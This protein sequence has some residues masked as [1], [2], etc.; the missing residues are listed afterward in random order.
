VDITRAAIEKNRIT[1]AILVIVLVGGWN[2]FNTLPRAEDPGFTIR[3]AQVITSFPGASP[4]RVEDLITDRLEKAIRELPEL[5]SIE[6]VSKTGISIITV[7]VQERYT[8]MRPIWD[9]LRRKVERE[10]A[11]MPDGAESPTV[12]DEFG[13]VFG[14][15]LA[16]TGDGFSY[17]E[18]KEIADEMRSELLRLEDTGKVEIFGTQEER[19]FIEFQNSRLTQLGVAPLELSNIL[20]AQ[21]IVTPGG[22]IRL[23]PERIVVEP[24][25]NFESIEDVGTTIVPLP[26]S[27]EVLYLRDLVSVSRGYIDPPSSKVHTGSG[28][29]RFHSRNLTFPGDEPRTAALALA[30]SMREGGLLTELG[31]RVDAEVDRF[32]ETYPIGIQIDKVVF[33]PYDVQEVVDGFTSNLLQ[34]VAVV[35]GAMLLFLGA[36]TGL[37]VSALIPTAMMATLFVM[38]LMGIGLDQ[39]SLAALIIALGM[40]VDNGVVMA[41]SIMV[42]M[43]AGQSGKEAAIRSARELRIP[44]LTSSLT[45]SAAFLPIFLAESATGEYTAAL[46][47]VVTIAL[48]ASWLLALTM[49]PLLCSVLLRVDV[50]SGGETFDGPFY[51][52]YRGALLALLRRPIPTLAGVLFVFGLTLYGAGKVPALFF[53]PS[54][55][56]GFEVELTLPEGTDIEYTRKVV[57]KLEGFMVETLIVEEDRSEGIIN[58]ATFIGQGAPRYYLSYGPEPRNPAYAIMLVDSTSQEARDEAMSQIRHY[59]AE[60]HPEVKPGVNPRQLGP[61]VSHPVQIRLTGIDTERLF[62]IVDDVKSRIREI[63]GAMNVGDDWGKRTKKILI[64][65]DQARARSAGATSQDVAISLQTIFSGLEVTQYREEEKVIP[66]TMRTEEEERLD[67]DDAGRTRADR[68]GRG[69]LGGVEDPA[70][71]L[72]AVGLGRGRRGGGDAGLGRDERLASLARRAIERVADRLSLRDRRRGGGGLQG[73]RLDRREA[74]DRGGHHRPAPRHAVQLAASAPD[75]PAHGSPR[76]DGGRGRALART[77]LFRLHD[78]ARRDLA[79]RHRDQQRDRADRSDRDRDRGER[80]DARGSRSLRGPDAASPDSLDDCDD[81]PRPGPALARRRPDVGAH[82]DRDHLRARLRHRAHARRRPLPLCGLLPSRLRG[83]RLIVV[84]HR[85]RGQLAELSLVE[86]GE[87]AQVIEAPEIRHPSD[88]QPTVPYPIQLAR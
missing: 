21:N 39:I 82:G 87:S 68:D 48:L 86:G 3:T 77:L 59:L 25:G 33:Q 61:P 12:N 84:S 35:M 51:Q 34:A 32:N 15:V 44:L 88:R 6:S 80:A 4:E 17:A 40:L 74:P 70:S 66:V 42:Q 18:L 1:A 24:S 63:P 5:E 56:P 31:K 28:A 65:V 41:E 2:A 49:T 10:A 79:L 7:N 58:W 14:I 57:Q 64:T 29:I 54:D 67:L 52:R 36:R 76:S 19:I 73:Q 69:R 45:T 60:N 16:L 23:G 53:P 37:V 27:E 50:S 13:D 11:S 26:D 71:E 75:H 83:R 20:E 38:Q 47:K 78:A 72:R 9:S 85:L 81:D 8:D 55:R 30:I 62:G 22:S 46:F 43:A